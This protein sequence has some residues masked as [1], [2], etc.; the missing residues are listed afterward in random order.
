MRL[1]TV[2][3]ARSLWFVY[4]ADL[5][6]HGRNLFSL[7]PIIIEKYNFKLFPNLNKLEEMDL[8][9]GIKFGHGG[10]QRDPENNIEID[11]T[12]YNDG[13]IADTRSSTSDSDA[14]LDQFLTWISSDFNFVPYK[15]VLRRKLYV[16]ELWVHTDK[17]LKS[18]NPRLE[19]FAKK[20]T[21]VIEGH[22]Y[23]DIDYEPVGIIFNTNP[24]LQPPGPFRFERLIDI[25]FAENRYYSGG[26]LQTEVHLEL[27]EELEN[28]LSS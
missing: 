20:I 13:F 21:S 3:Q 15:E 5:N 10:F 4:L 1:L 6:P 23:H 9:K 28:I 12:I 11:L 26:P 22:T 7:V 24:V 14:F 17:S 18:L 8:Q 19:N 16:S 25:P 27:L 2:K